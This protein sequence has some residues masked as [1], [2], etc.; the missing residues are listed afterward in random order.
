[1]LNP[2]KKKKQ[3]YVQGDGEE[4]ILSVSV[5]QFCKRNLLE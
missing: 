4:N 5:D 1:M 2:T 3:P